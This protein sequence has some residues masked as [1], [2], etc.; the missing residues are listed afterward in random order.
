MIILQVEWS[1]NRFDEIVS[2]L[3]QFL[4]T[5]VG[6][7]KKGIFYIPCSG[8]TGENLLKKSQLNILSMQLRN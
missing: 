2:K 5:Q 1:K 3:S 8:L 7:K 4:L 6:F